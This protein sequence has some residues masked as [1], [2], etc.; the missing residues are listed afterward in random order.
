MSRVVK[1]SSNLIEPGQ[2]VSKYTTAE[3][4]SRIFG[5]KLVLVVEQMQILTI[6]LVKACLL[7]MYNRMTLVLPQHRIVVGTAIYVAIAFVRGV[8]SCQNAT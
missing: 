7:I 8:P 4:D 1:T 3:I 6:W 2:D 5:S